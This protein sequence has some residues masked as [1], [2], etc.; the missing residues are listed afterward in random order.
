MASESPKLPPDA[1]WLGEST[2]YDYD[3]FRM[4]I[5]KTIGKNG[6]S[7]RDKFDIYKVGIGF[8]FV[9]KAVS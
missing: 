2:V 8:L 1:V 4:Y 3:G 7:D 6:I 5:P 9:P